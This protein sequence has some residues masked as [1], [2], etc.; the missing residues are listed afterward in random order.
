MDLNQITAAQTQP[1]N[2]LRFDPEA[3]EAAIERKERIIAQVRKVG[4]ILPIALQRIVGIR[5]FRKIAR[6]SLVR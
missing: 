6:R 2:Q 3:F 1:Q 5:A 4:R